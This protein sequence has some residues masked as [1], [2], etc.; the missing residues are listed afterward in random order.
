[1][2]PRLRWCV[3]LLLLAGLSP[4]RV[5][6][7]SRCRGGRCRRSRGGLTAQ[8][9]GDPDQDGDAGLAG[10]A[11]GGAEGDAGEGAEGP[12]PAAQDGVMGTGTLIGLVQL[13]A[14]PR[15]ATTGIARTFAR[16]FLRR[17]SLDFGEDAVASAVPVVEKHP[18]S[19]ALR[20]QFDELRRGADTSA[21]LALQPAAAA[22]PPARAN[23][24]F[25]AYGP[26]AP[27]LLEERRGRT[28][29]L[30]ALRDATKILTRRLSVGRARREDKAAAAPEETP[31]RRPPADPVPDPVRG[32]GTTGVDDILADVA[33][34]IDRR[35]RDAARA[36]LTRLK[37]GLRI[38]IAR[39]RAA[40]PPPAPAE[41]AP[42]PADAAA[43]L[44]SALEV[45]GGCEA[46]PLGEEAMNVPLLLHSCLS[47]SG[48]PRAEDPKGS[49]TDAFGGRNC[50][51]AT[52]SGSDGAVRGCLALCEDLRVA[53]LSF[54]CDVDAA[55]LLTD[56]T[57]AS[58]PFNKAP[59]KPFP[60]SE[61]DDLDLISLPEALRRASAAGA[62]GSAHESLVDL[63]DSVHRKILTDAK[64]REDYRWI[65]TGHGVGGAVA[66]LAAL[67]LWESGAL[68]EKPLLVTFGAPAVGDAAFCE[69]VEAAA[70]PGG[71]LR[72]W[73]DY[74]VVPSVSQIV[75]LEHAGVPLK[76]AAVDEDGVSAKVEGE[77][78]ATAPHNVFQVGPILHVFR[79]KGD[80]APADGGG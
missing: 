5:A 8:L 33:A 34:R 12:A 49:A 28:S 31:R 22:A 72:V 57:F 38:E 35:Q 54:D 16:Q 70:A 52:F 4:G 77:T 10:A 23:F 7:R 42:A 69:A 62:G 13:G 66:Q 53:A 32:G 6:L 11:R 58:K 50:S 59:Q 20:D 27:A 45:L 79:R 48:L 76:L 3:V 61:D 65:V 39:W 74:D 21:L 15:G 67:R 25:P 64:G 78:M 51:A 40:V 75:G 44:R 29:R 18:L 46:L 37:V 9:S 71:G 2:C 26:D 41:A 47:F 1:M 43:R 56:A 63:Y 30:R 73:N 17:Y 24:T 55:D 36:E 14:Q 60:P 80:A 68:R 19:D